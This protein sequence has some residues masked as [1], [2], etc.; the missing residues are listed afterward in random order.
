VTRLLSG[1][2]VPF[3]N[4][5]ANVCGVLDARDMVSMNEQ[6]FKCLII[7]YLTRE[8]GVTVLSEVQCQGGLFVDIGI[9]SATMPGIIWILELKYAQLPF[10]SEGPVIRANTEDWQRLALTTQKHRL[11]VAST[12]VARRSAFFF[13]DANMQAY[14]NSHGVP[15][16]RLL[17]KPPATIWFDIN[18][19]FFAATRQVRGY[20]PNGYTAANTRRFVVVGA[21]NSVWIHTA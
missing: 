1:N 16:T 7:G 2:A 8:R 11:W 13:A 20:T 3:Q 6:A 15:L 5:I 21:G 14:F 19:L 10:W 18:A 17:G 4:A 9:T 12:D